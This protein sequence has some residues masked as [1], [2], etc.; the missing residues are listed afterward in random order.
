MG[1]GIG[2]VGGVQVEKVSVVVGVHRP[3][4]RCVHACRGECGEGAVAVAG[5]GS[6]RMTVRMVRDMPEGRTWEWK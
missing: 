4:W 1:I 3:G 6:T 2:W 5:A